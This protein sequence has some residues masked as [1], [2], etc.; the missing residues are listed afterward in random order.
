MHRDDIETA[1]KVKT[2]FQTGLKFFK[3][4]FDFFKDLFHTS[5]GFS[6]ALLIKKIRFWR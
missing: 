2:Y 5:E 1:K 3:G 6:I 4:L